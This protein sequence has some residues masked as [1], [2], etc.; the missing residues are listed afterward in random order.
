MKAKKITCLTFATVL[1]ASTSLQ[2][3]CWP[4]VFKRKKPDP[5]FIAKTKTFV[6]KISKTTSN[7]VSEVMVLENAKY[8][9]YGVAGATLLVLVYY[10]LR[11]NDDS[12]MWSF[13]E[14]LGDAPERV[15]GNT[16]SKLKEEYTEYKEDLKKREKAHN[17]DQKDKPEPVPFDEKLLTAREWLEDKM[18]ENLLKD[19]QTDDSEITDEKKEEL[20]NSFITNANNE[21]SDISDKFTTQINGRNDQ[22]TGKKD[23]IEKLQGEI[24]ALEQE[25]VGDDSEK[26]TEIDKKKRDLELVNVFLENIQ[27]RRTKKQEEIQVELEK[28]ASK[29]D[30][31]TIMTEHILTDKEQAHTEENI[32]IMGEQMLK[33]KKLSPEVKNVV[34]KLTPNLN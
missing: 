26:N 29:A 30:L 1:L 5:S 25:N 8:G 28:P 11:G 17:E 4:S 14:R 20:I 33:D 23:D 16:P 3:L 34:M 7:K 24:E 13:V 9:L 21:I 22:V 12:K 32:K 31:L 18:F 10:L 2:A 6:S 19:N 27:G 15:F